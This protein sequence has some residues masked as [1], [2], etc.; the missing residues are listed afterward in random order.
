MKFTFILPCRNRVKMANEAIDCLKPL[1]NEGNDCIVIDDFSD[2]PDD[3]YH[4]GEN[5]N[6]IYNKFKSSLTSMWNIGAKKSKNEYIVFIS[7]KIRLCPKDIQIFTD[8]LNKGFGIVCTYRLGC[9]ALHVSLFNITGMF[10]E[11]FVEGGYEDTDYMNRLFAHD[12]AFYFSQETEYVK[13][14]AN[15]KTTGDNQK[16]YHLKWNENLSTIKCN[17]NEENISDRDYFKNVK[18]SQFLPFKDS[19]IKDNSVSQYYK[20]RKFEG[21][22]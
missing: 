16:Y 8:G 13:V 3:S 10:D 2:N 12:I 14:P 9:F 11:G 4:T 6:I 18:Q 21:I 22:R 1:L 7:D 5:I 15:W 17:K 19:Q 20:N